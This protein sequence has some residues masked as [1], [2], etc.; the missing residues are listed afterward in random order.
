MERLLDIAAKELDIDRMAIRRR[1]FI[2][3]EQF[4]YA[5]EIIFQDF[6]Q[7]VYDSGN[8]EPA[9]DRALEL[10]GYQEF[11]REEQ[12]RREAAGERVGIA[13]VSYIEGTGIGPYEGA[14][15]TVEASGQVSVATGV[16]HKARAT[17]PVLPKS[18]PTRSG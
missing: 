18:W 11:I 14:R 5:N 17:T 10:I 3:P 2:R 16:A 1:N 4:P 12:P 7:L 9:L 6:T 15:V 13:V 8:Y